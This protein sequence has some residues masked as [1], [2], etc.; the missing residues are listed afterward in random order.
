MRTSRQ[1]QGEGAGTLSVARAVWA[2]ALLLVACKPNL[3]SPPSLIDGPRL[4]G[5]RETPPEVMPGAPAMF[6][7]LAVNAD[8]TVPAS[9]AWTLCLT[10]KPPA[11]SNS[12]SEACVVQPDDGAPVLGVTTLTMPPDACALFGPDPPPVTPPIAPRN[13]DATGGF[14]VPVRA[15]NQAADGTDLLSFA[16]ERISCNLA[17][18]PAD[19]VRAYNMTYLPNA[20]PSI[21][22]VVLDPDGAAPLSILQASGG[23]GAVASGA[24]VTLRLSWPDTAAESY[25]LY[26]PASRT[27]LDAREG[28][29]VSWF[30]NGGALEDDR[31]GRSGAE[32]ETSTDNVWTPPT[33][34]AA[35][36]VH[37]WVVLRDDRGGVDF[38]T[39]DLTVT[40]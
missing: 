16:F 4:L 21:E 32:A 33:V 36:I 38:A 20:A 10:P 5:I 3:G 35:T 8:G 34:A 6:E 29:N 28:L 15:A 22:D 9:I 19:V 2:G 37:F 14:Y 18:A 39:F 12:V 17:N 25:V 11:E 23:A 1:R 13:P 40:P 7:A 31:T 24:P 27:L 26:D 30:A